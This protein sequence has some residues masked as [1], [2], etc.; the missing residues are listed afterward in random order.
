MEGFKE[1]IGTGAFTYKPNK[2]R[3]PTKTYGQKENHAYSI[4]IFFFFVAFIF[5]R[6]TWRSLPFHRTDYL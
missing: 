5:N 6:V 4:I 2:Q 3:F 1:Y